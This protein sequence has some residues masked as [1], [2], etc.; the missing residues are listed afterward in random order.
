MRFQVLLD[1]PR[2][3]RKTIQIAKLGSFKDGR[4]GEFSIGEQD[5]AD[6][7]RNLDKLPGGRA[8]ID[9]DHAADKQPRRTEA[10]GWITDVRIADGV[11]VADVE[12][13]S[14]GT[15][16]I[17]DGRYLFF[18]PTYGEFKDEG[19]VAHDN[20]LIGGALTNRP[21]LN[22]PA[23]TL[24]SAETLRAARVSEEEQ[25]RRLLDAL[26]SRKPL[27]VSSDSRRTMNKDLLKALGLD[28]TA[29][30]QKMLDA[31]TQLKAKA[32]EKPSEKPEPE[33]AS[34]R[35]LEQQAAD[36]GKILLDTARFTD[37]NRK[38][39]LGEQASKQLAAQTFERSYEKALAA[40]RAVPAQ[41][42]Q[43]EHFY[44]LDAESTLKLLDDGPQLVNTRPAGGPGLVEDGTPDGVHPESHK[45]DQAVKAKLKELGKP[46]SEYENVYR[47]LMSEAV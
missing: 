23:L 35:T 37:L 13:T 40:G 33:P 15:A 7:K 19:G 12:W 42:E 25:D 41:K 46:M 38:A 14:K 17:Q 2:E 4:Y 31:V 9:E 10:S 32:D 18:S 47:L 29:D 36:D 26:T 39:D 45:L 6:W 22:M 30:E 8:L 24:A 20:T 5:V 34:T 16:A 28:E 11:P 43:L 44:T 1:A 3:P 21:F 27:A